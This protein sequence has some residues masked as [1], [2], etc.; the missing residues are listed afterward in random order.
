ML[1]DKYDMCDH[2]TPVCVEPPCEPVE[3]RR[4]TGFLQFHRKQF[5]GY[6][7]FLNSTRFLRDKPH[8]I[9]MQAKFVMSEDLILF[10]SFN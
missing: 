10:L 1:L 8:N 2:Y 9:K 3:S 5:P 7:Y 6:I 4:N